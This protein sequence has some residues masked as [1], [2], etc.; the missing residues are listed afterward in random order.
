MMHSVATRERWTVGPALELGRCPEATTG[1][2]GVLPLHEPSPGRRLAACASA[3]GLSA[4]DV[5]VL[6]AAYSRWP[7]RCSS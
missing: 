1:H 7:S 6:S 5:S 2:P 3:S 4:N